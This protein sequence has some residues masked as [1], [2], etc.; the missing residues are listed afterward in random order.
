MDKQQ[1]SEADIISKFILPSI[2]SAGWDTMTQIRQEVKLRDGKV[3]VYMKNGTLLRQ[4]IN[5]QNE[6]DFTDSK[7]K[8][9]FGDIY[10]QY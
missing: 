8:H 2:T 1:L 10:E 9:T 3:I 4:V 7:E 5:K 6:I